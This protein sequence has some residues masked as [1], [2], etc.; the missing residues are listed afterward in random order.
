MLSCGCLGLTQVNMRC[1]EKKSRCQEEKHHHDSH[2]NEDGGR[3]QP[4]DHLPVKLVV[5]IPLLFHF[6][7]LLDS[8]CLPGQQLPGFQTNCSR[9]AVRLCKTQGSVRKPLVLAVMWMSQQESR[10]CNSKKNWTQTLN[11]LTLTLTGIKPQL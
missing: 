2:E 11:P 8:V 6:F 1:G 3:G 7:I 10:P 5:F 4:C 9:K